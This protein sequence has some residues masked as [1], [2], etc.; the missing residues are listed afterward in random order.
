MNLRGGRRDNQYRHSRPPSNAARTVTM[1]RLGWAII[2]LGTAY[3]LPAMAADV[4]LFDLIKKPAY[5]H[6]LKAL[7]KDAKE[8]EFP[9]WLSKL[10]STRGDYVSV[11]IEY[12][13]IGGTQ[14]G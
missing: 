9:F 7:L 10:L 1:R 5:A 3:A 13:T 8:P 2:L 12:V 11:P 14:Y 4:Y 6:S